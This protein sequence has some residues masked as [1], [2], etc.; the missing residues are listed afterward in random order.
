MDHS[1]LTIGR[2]TRAAGVNVEVVRYYQRVG[3]IREPSIMLA[4]I[5]PHPARGIPVKAMPHK[6]LDIAIFKR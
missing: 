6:G 5:L 1:A 3:L 2:L 4:Q